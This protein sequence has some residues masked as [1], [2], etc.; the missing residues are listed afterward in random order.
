M[1][2]TTTIL[3]IVLTFITQYA[4][5][6]IAETCKFSGVLTVLL[7]KDNSDRSEIENKGVIAA[8]AYQDCRNILKD[9][10]EKQHGMVKI[11]II[12]EGVHDGILRQQLGLPDLEEE[13]RR[14]FVEAGEDELAKTS[15]N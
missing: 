3:D 1:L 13:I 5:Y 12:K 9:L 11:L 14:H 10:L 4:M 15:R 7:L 6:M 2:P 8:T